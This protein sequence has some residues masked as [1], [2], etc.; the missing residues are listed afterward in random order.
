MN[1][2]IYIIIILIAFFVTRHIIYSKQTNE[3]VSYESMKYD[4]DNVK[5]NSK[6]R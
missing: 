4:L 3:P 6:Y 2:I 1:K 5:N